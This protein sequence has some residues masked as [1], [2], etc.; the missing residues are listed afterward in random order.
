MSDTPR[1]DKVIREGAAY[2]MW[3]SYLQ[4]RDHAM[5]LERELVTM[6]VAKNK[7]VEALKSVVADATT[8][9]GGYVIHTE[10]IDEVLLPLIAKMEEV[11]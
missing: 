7:A 5:Q 10:I 4:M 9:A 8:G 11:K 1:T 2:D 6:T 3:C